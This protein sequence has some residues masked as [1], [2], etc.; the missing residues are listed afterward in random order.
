MSFAAHARTV[1]PVVR[2]LA[3]SPAAPPS[4]PYSVEV[5][6]PEVG[7]VR[8]TG[9]LQATAGSSRRGAGGT[10]STLLVL[11][12]GL[13]GSTESS[14]MLRT[15][16]LAGDLGLATLRLNLRGADRRGGDLY[17]A[18]LSS[19]LDW[20]L[21]SPELAAFER[22]L[23]FGFSLGGHM[24]LRFATEAADPR[25]SAVA[26]ACAPLD[27]ERCVAAI[28]RPAGWVYRRY[29]LAGL[30]EMYAEVAAR[31]Q[32]PLTVA[33]ARRIRTLREWDRHTVVPRF[34]FDSPEDYYRRAAVGG[35][36]DRLK[37]PALLVVAEGDPMVPPAAVR[38]GTNGAPG[39]LTLRSSRRGG[40]L[41]FPASLDLGED[42]PL[43]LA[44]QVIGWLRRQQSA[45]G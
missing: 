16:A 35:R 45:P 23:V 1:W 27:L 19:D 28:D 12:H 25:L 33:E 15:A 36:L 40:H 24:T 42:A 41:A 10:S 13:G 30:C 31:R 26:A 18:G 20:V 38:Q 8:L 34:G 44:G 3:V 43:G 29:V 7:P 22:I 32:L 6:D 4:V 21:A 9:R 14:Y 5:P 17:H 39:D 11:V 2:R 37:V